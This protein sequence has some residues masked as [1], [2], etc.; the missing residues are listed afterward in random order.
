MIAER[1]RAVRERIDAAAR[2]AGRDPAQVQLLAVSKTFP[3]RAVL[4]AADAGQRCFAENRVQ[5]A[6]AKI[7]EVGRDLEWHLVGALQRNKARRAVELF[8]VIHSVDRPQLA[9]ALQ[10]AA[11]AA[12]RRPRVL[13]QVNLDAEDQKSGAAPEALGALLDAVRACPALV[14]S[15]LMTIPRACDDPEEV[16]PSFARLAELARELRATEPRLVELSM[17]MSADFEVAVEEGATLVR[18]GT[19]IFGTRS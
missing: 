9:H 13:L 10:R 7:P 19:A 16:R 6:E 2:R 3:A 14:P 15:G 4:E 17:G 18:V 5:E 1:L 8:D 12:G 11:D